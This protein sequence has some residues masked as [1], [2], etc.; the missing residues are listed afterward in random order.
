MFD[1]IVRRE[2]AFEVLEFRIGRTND[3]PSFVSMRVTSRDSPNLA[4]LF[5][6]LVTLG[7]RV[8]RADDVHLVPADR[9]GCT[10]DDFYSTTNHQTFVRVEG[11]WI[12]VDRQRMDA[13][14][15][16]EPA[17]P[18]GSVDVRAVCRKLRDLRRGDYVVC[19][20]RGVKLVTEFQAR[21]ALG[22]VLYPT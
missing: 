9:N 22:I 17:V 19:G 1:T 8:A 11:K 18:D 14:I 3:E 10:P 4:E 7:C 16:V 6:E 12:P 15:V 20:F 21:H 13:P 2:A 5:D